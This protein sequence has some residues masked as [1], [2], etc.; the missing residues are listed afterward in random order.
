MTT[1]SARPGAGGRTSGSGL[2]LP[3]IPEQLRVE[4]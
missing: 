2:L 4:V 3:E 1:M